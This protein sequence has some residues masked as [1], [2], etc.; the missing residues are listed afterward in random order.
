[1][2]ERRFIFIFSLLF[3]FFPQ[4]HCF[5]RITERLNQVVG[6]NKDKVGI[7]FI[8]L[9][10]TFEVEVNGRK[11]FPAASVIKVPVMAAAFR[12]QEKG[13]INLLSKVRYKESDRLEGS[14]VLRWM[15][16]GGYYTLWNLT[17]LMIVLSDN[18][19]TKMVIDSLGMNKINDYLLSIGLSST[20]I[21]DSTM[22]MEPPDPNVNLT[23]PY[24]M[25]ELMVKI[26]KSCGFNK[27]SSKQMIS[28]L[29]NQRYRWGIWRGIGQGA[30]V[31]DKTGN[32]EGVLN[33]VG[34]IYTKRGDYVLSVFTYGFKKQKEARLMINE[35]S[36]VVYEEY[37]GAKVVF[38]A[39]KVK[40]KITYKSKRI[41]HKKRFR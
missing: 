37:T 36:R 5:S 9:K 6:E 38:P 4:C 17:R 31:A 15:K 8:D 20:K 25:A 41:R 13:I 34:I 22:L 40:K 12:F 29:K 27:D 11:E 26:Y 10:G 30:S 21:T 23:S 32:L 28:F 2:K 1:M 3:L 24:D 35:I 18:T 33:D 7:V 39:K 16:A 14:G 19:A